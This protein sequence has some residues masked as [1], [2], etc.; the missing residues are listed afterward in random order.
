MPIAL[1]FVDGLGIGERNPEKNPFAKFP[2]RFFNF[3]L[4]EPL[5]DLPFGGKVIPTAADM[6]V[7]G[8]PQSATGQTAIFCGIKSA[9]I[10]GHHISG[11]PTSTLRELLRAH[12]IFRKLRDAGKTAAFANALSQEYFDH[13]GERISAT[14]RALLA[15][16]FPWRNFD[17]L[18][19]GRAVSHDLTNEFLR[20]M[21]MDA[22][23]RTPAESAGILADIIS[24]NDFTLFE[25]ILTDMVGHNQEMAAAGKVIEKL[26]AL[27]S[28]TLSRMDLQKTT[29]LLTSDHG[30]FED[31]S[32]KTHTMN[33]VPT[34]V[35]GKGQAIVLGRVTAIE[36]IAGAIFEICLAS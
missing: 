9:Q 34:M 18:R 2:S 1:L 26:D 19:D 35:W 24:Q 10:V 29:I 27:L 13:R 16:D 12:S 3:F 31:L 23:I 8:L 14:T 30:N 6:G 17:D 22:P 33:P 25:F 20:Q 4:N 28:V 5:P 7:A 15:G 21:K 36:D 11:F 32:V